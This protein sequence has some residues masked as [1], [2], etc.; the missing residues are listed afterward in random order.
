MM[1]KDTRPRSKAPCTVPGSVT[2]HGGR[3]IGPHQGII[4]RW[5]APRSES[6]TLREPWK[7]ITLGDVPQSQTERGQRPQGGQTP[8]AVEAPGLRPSQSNG[9]VGGLTF[10]CL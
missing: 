10:S 8:W 1:G 9:I 5:S 3:G 2:L 4:Q 7:V 6:I